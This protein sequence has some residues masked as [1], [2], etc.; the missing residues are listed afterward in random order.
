MNDYFQKLKE[1]D[2]MNDMCEMNKKKNET[3]EEINKHFETIR[4]GNEKRL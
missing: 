2:E 4:I 3:R 1:I